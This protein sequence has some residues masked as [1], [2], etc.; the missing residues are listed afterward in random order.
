MG[1]LTWKQ[2][3]IVC[4]MPFLSNAQIGETLGTGQNQTKIHVSDIYRK[5][6]VPDYPSKID[7][8]IA[9]V[10]YALVQAEITFGL[11]VSIATRFTIQKWEE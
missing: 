3:K 8:R 4:L 10:V 7:K 11:F 5:L 9:A 2:R 1:K 6:G